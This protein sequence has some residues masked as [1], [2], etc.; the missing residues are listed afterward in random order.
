MTIEGLIKAKG[1]E[2]ALVF[3]TEE[4]AKIVVSKDE[5][6]EQDVVKILDIVMGETNLDSSNIKIMKKN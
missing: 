2:E 1:F 5:L 4:N 3:I 6:T